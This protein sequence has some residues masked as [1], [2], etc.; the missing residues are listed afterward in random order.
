LKDRHAKP[1]DRLTYRLFE[2]TVNNVIRV[3][4]E[5]KGYDQV[6]LNGVNRKLL[7][8][9]AKPEK[10]LGVQ[11]PSQTLW[12]DEEYR[13]VVTEGEVPGLG[14]LTLRR[15]TKEK[16]LAPNGKLRDL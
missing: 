8:V 9:L 14:E 5:V 1:G 16:A 15:T 10:I 12:Y 7:R 13:P 6:P 11:L 2:P 3:Q 4:V